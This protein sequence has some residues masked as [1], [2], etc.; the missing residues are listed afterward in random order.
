MTANIGGRRRLS[1]RPLRYKMHAGGRPRTFGSGLQNPNRGFDSHRRLQLE[2]QELRLFS[3]DSNAKT[4]PN[5]NR[6]SPA[7]SGC[8][9]SRRKWGG[10]S[11]PS[12]W[13]SVPA[14]SWRS[15]PP[16]ATPPSGWRP[17]RGVRVST[18]VSNGCQAARP[19]PSGA[20]FRY[21]S[22]WCPGSSVDRAT[23]S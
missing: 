6:A 10:I 20:V 18:W 2:L 14:P 21:N 5:G 23:V 16:A 11:T 19:A 7:P 22:A 15:P 9:R 17:P 4:P 1:G 8:A 12:C 13:P 3:I